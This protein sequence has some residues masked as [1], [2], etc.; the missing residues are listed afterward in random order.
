MVEIYLLYFIEFGTYVKYILNIVELFNYR[1]YINISR[2]ENNDKV[3]DGC[4]NSVC[5]SKLLK[6]EYSAFVQIKEYKTG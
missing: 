5:S 4:I 6:T 1:L 2:I 3:C